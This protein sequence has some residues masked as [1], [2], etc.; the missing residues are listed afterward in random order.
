MNISFE[1]HNFL[2][3]DEAGMNKKRRIS[4]S[5]SITFDEWSVISDFA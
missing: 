2:F 1:I 4:S 3:G 5:L